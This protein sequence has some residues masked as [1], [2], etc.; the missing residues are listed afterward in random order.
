MAEAKVKEETL[1]KT[2]V[3]PAKKRGCVGFFVHWIFILCLLLAAFC[4]GWIYN[5]YEH[6]NG[7][8]SEVI[9]IGTERAGKLIRTL[10]EQIRGWIGQA[11]DKAAETVKEHQK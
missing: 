6:Q 9:R 3:A 8:T 7:N 11:T 1:A 4:S 10:T 2:P 5:E